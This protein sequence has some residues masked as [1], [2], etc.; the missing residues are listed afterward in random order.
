MKIGLYGGTFD[1]PHV[2]H[3][4]LA[5]TLKSEFLLDQVWWI[6]SGDPPH[7]T[8][9]HVTPYAHRRAMVSLAV[10]DNPAFFVKDYER[11]RVGPTYTVHTLEDVIRWFPQHSFYL[12]LGGDS[13]DQLHTWKDGERIPSMVPLLVFHR[14]QRESAIMGKNLQGRVRFSTAPRILLAGTDIRKRVSENQPIRYLMSESVRSYIESHGL[15]L[16]R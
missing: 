5:E 1:P 7:K 2:A 16:R 3:Q 15:Y 10:E 14:G 13:L 8:G 4:F 11:D 9:Q 6:P 12:L